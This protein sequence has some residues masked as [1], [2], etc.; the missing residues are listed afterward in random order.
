MM[1]KIETSNIK[2]ERKVAIK[3]IHLKF[4]K[5]KLIN[6]MISNR[7]ECKIW[8]KNGYD[9]KFLKQNAIYVDSFIKKFN[10]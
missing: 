2:Y 6:L 10:E 5:S 1:G 4:L 9:F 3:T 8:G 7:H